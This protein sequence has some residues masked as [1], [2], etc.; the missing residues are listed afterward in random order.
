[1]VTT[2]KKDKRNVFLEAVNTNCI[3]EGE[4]EEKAAFTFSSFSF[5][6][7]SAAAVPWWSTIQGHATSAEVKDTSIGPDTVPLLL[8][9]LL[10]T[11]KY[12]EDGAN[13]TNCNVRLKRAITDPVDFLQTPSWSHTL[14]IYLTRNGNLSISL[15]K[16][17]ITAPGGRYT[18]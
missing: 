12:E 3:V 15:Q 11:L 16:K 17:V 5:A 9:L 14:K 18:N 1:M 13:V 2:P 8:L 10:A 6:L 7:T 4:R